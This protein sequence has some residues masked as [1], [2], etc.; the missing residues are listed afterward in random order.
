[1][2]TIFEGYEIRAVHQQAYRS[3]WGA[4]KDNQYLVFLKNLE[5]GE[6]CSFRY[7]SSNTVYRSMHTNHDL[8]F[9]VECFLSDAISGSNSFEEFCHELGYDLYDD[10]SGGYNKKSKKIYN[11]CKRSYKSALRVVGNDDDIYTLSNKIIDLKNG[12]YDIPIVE[13]SA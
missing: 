4:I 11:A 6:Q 9:A 1:M 3:N 10:Y 7:W 8:I 2:K 5:S 12:D 13:L